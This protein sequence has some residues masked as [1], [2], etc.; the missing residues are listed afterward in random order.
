MERVGNRRKLKQREMEERGGDL[1]NPVMLQIPPTLA[2]A[3]NKLALRK[4]TLSKQDNG[5]LTLD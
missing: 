5:S 4:C 1:L 3:P 2:L